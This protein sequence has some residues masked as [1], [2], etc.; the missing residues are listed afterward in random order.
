[1]SIPG[2]GNMVADMSK[3]NNTYYNNGGMIDNDRQ[4]LHVSNTVSLRL[5]HYFDVFRRPFLCAYDFFQM[6]CVLNFWFEGI[7]THGNN[8]K[9]G[10][11]DQ[12]QSEI[13]M[14]YGACVF[15]AIHSNCVHT[16]N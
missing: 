5:F 1:M 11:T 6:V 4:W 7:A 8:T 12:I 10:S 3:N 14:D 16:Q 9:T 2:S 15:I 13:A